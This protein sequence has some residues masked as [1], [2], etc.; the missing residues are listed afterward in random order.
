MKV[1]VTVIAITRY[2]KGTGICVF[3]SAREADLWHFQ[4][5]MNSWG[6]EELEYWFANHQQGVTFDQAD[7]YDLIGGY[8]EWNAEEVKFNQE[9]VEIEFTKEELV[10][11]LFNV[12][13]S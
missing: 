11:L 9:T 5:C 8:Y 6:K 13:E 1:P 10:T 3:K 2:G 12:R 7:M 4:V